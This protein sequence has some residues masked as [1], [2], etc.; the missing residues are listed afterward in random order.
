MNYGKSVGQCGAS[1]TEVIVAIAILAII[2]GA[3]VGGLFVSIQGDQVARTRISAESLARYELEYV[4]A[5]N[6]WDTLSWTYVLPGA[7]PFFDVSHGALPAGY[8][9]Y[10]VA[11]SANP[12]PGYSGTSNIQKITAAVR[13][14]GNLVLSIDTY[15]TQ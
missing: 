15:R 1:L 13:Y 11:V 3:L 8:D 7:P 6:Y 10:S 14:N 12:A 5:T 4:K 9:G 2:T